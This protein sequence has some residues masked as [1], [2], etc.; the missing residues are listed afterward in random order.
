MA[1]T[2][3]DVGKKIVDFLGPASTLAAPFLGPVGPF[4]PLAIKGLSLALGVKDPNPQPDVI[5]KAIEA[6]PQAATELAK[7]QMAYEH[8]ITMKQMEYEAQSRG[9]QAGINLQDA[10]DIRFWNS[11]WRPFIGW[12]CGTS[13]AVYYIPQALM[14]T[15]LWVIA[16]A[17]NNWVI[18]PFPNTFDISELMGLLISLLGLGGLKTVEKIKGVTK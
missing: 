8:D 2:W 5:I 18:V 13:L 17:N 15:I 11:G 1:S 7:A 6:N 4:L 14:A 12:V 9:E 3:T 10:K 16:V